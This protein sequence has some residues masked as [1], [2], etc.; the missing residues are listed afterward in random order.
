L[1]DVYPVLK[2]GKIVATSIQF[3]NAISLIYICISSKVHSNQK[4]TRVRYRQ[5]HK[6]MKNNYG[7]KLKNHNDKS[8]K[9]S[10]T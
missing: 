10:K 5:L 3:N 7:I 9:K 1:K 4:I 8:S 2:Y 6:L